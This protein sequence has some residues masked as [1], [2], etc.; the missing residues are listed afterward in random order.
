VSIF[1]IVGGFGDTAGS[2]LTAAKKQS[3]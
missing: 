1:S 3:N 2:G